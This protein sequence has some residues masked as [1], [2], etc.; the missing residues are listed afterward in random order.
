MKLSLTA[1]KCVLCTGLRIKPDS[2]CWL[3]FCLGL[4]LSVSDRMYLLCRTLGSSSLLDTVWCFYGIKKLIFSSLL[5]CYW[6]FLAS[7]QGYVLHSV[8]CR[9]GSVNIVASKLAMILFKDWGRVE[10]GGKR[11]TGKVSSILSFG[12]SL[13][14]LSP[15]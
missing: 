9:C 3:P 14:T 13:Q 8:W 1:L 4:A 6:I 15:C 10:E 7:H 11:R 2:E 12:R 5:H